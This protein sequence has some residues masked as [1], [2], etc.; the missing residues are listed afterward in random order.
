MQVIVSVPMQVII[1]IVNWD[2][3]VYCLEQMPNI[4]GDVGV[5]YLSRLNKIM[6]MVC[7]W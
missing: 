5:V 6:Q 4:S 2:F 1:I 7:K 3:A